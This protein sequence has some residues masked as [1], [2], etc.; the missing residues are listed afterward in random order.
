MQIIDYTRDRAN[1]NHRLVLVFEILE[2]F[3]ACLAVFQEVRI[4]GFTL[5]SKTS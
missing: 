5:M 3:A 1:L 2:V 4:I